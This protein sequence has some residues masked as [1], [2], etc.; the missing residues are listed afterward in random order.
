[1]LKNH[2]KQ[3][4]VTTLYMVRCQK[5]PLQSAEKHSKNQATVN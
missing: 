5:T 2:L 1:M 3:F 4:P